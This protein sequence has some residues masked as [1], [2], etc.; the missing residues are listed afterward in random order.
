M[1]TFA[2]LARLCYCV[3]LTSSL[4]CSDGRQARDAAV[5]LD[6]APST[7]Q[8]DA[9]DSLAD[10][11]PAVTDASAREDGDDERASDGAGMVDGPGD[12]E[13]GGARA[14]WYEKAR[15]GTAL[16][17][18]GF[19]FV[20]PDRVTYSCTSDPNVDA[21]PPWPRD[22]KGVV[23]GASA[24]QFTID[25]CVAQDACDPGVYT[26]TVDVPGLA[27]TVPVGRR[28]RVQWQIAVF[29]GCTSW[30]AVSDDTPDLTGTV[31]FVGNGGFQKPPFDLPFDVGLDQLDCRLPA[32]AYRTSC[33]GA[34][35]GDYAFR[36]SSRYG[37]ASSLT[38]GTTESGS[39]TFQNSAGLMQSLAVHCLQAF[40]T[41][42]CDD[43][44]SWDFW[45]V[46]TSATAAGAPLDAAI[47]L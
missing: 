30:L 44:W 22:L 15:A 25:T 28:V 2:R 21:G 19:S 17:S 11:A 35:T 12:V 7:P 33:S 34:L 1:K 31:W 8:P 14:C 10:V 6:A 42:M 16:M 43:Y 29:W 24:T 32:D 3:L 45:A 47:D 37:S 41:V 18:F 27:L 36:F 4:A 20:G 39:F 26:F 38:L 23:T 9:A 5:G 46:N 13:D 40:Q